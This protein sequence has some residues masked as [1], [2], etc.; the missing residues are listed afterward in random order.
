MELSERLNEIRKIFAR[1]KTIEL[2]PT[3]QAE[4]VGLLEQKY[5]FQLPKEYRAF[6]TT[7]GNGA[8]LQPI[9]NDCD[10]LCPF[11]DSPNLALAAKP[12]PLT[13]SMDWTEDDSFGT[14]SE[15]DEIEQ[16]NAA[17][18][19]VTQNGQLVLMH[20]PCEGGLTWVLIVTGERQ[21]EVWLRDE[22]GY[23]RLPDCSFLDW[24]EL[25][26]NKKL[27]RL[28]NDLFREQKMN[29]KKE[30]PMEKIR[31]LMTKKSNQK[32]QWNPPIPM[33]E[34]LAFEARHNITLPEEYKQ[35]ITE[36]ADGCNKFNSN[37]SV[38]GGTFYSLKD[39]DSLLNLD[40]PF[41]FQENTDKVRY[42]LTHVLGPE[43][44][45]PENPVWISKFGEISRE[46]P[47]SK[48]WASPDYSVLH[49]VLP[50]AFYNDERGHECLDL[51][52]QAVLIVNGPLKGQVWRAKKYIL[53]P[54]KEDT[55]FFSWIID[56]L[57]GYIA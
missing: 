36:V 47:L 46:D 34:V 45:G 56:M 44:Y 29:Q 17:F 21:G 6:I 28:V 40:K 14:G 8:T 10:E 53:Y 23:L 32:I 49:G 54:G 2:K 9:S 24:L 1:R 37:N 57:E 27:M 25:Y 42:E 35:F 7:L 4:E 43:A 38:E 18:D 15:D 33:S 12:F 11:A 5:G 50:F 22:D 19:A 41:Y 16:S 13:E 30:P 20:D 26:L 55:T 31:S 39:M 51:N 52:T 48:V 3:I